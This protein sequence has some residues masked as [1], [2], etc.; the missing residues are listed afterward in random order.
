MWHVLEWIVERRAS[1]WRSNFMNWMKIRIPYPLGW[2]T[3][4][5]LL[6]LTTPYSTRQLQHLFSTVLL[7]LVL[8]CSSQCTLLLLYIYI[9]LY[10]YI[11]QRDW[12]NS[13]GMKFVRHTAQRHIMNIQLDA[14]MA[15][16]QSIIHFSSTIVRILRYINIY[17]YMYFSIYLRMCSLFCIIFF[18][19][20]QNIDLHFIYLFGNIYIVCVICI[21]NL[22]ESVNVWRLGSG[23]RCIF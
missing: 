9:Y 11:R 21:L 10:T 12:R 17:M 8:I 18:A 6:L 16:F 20:T 19:I 14:G 5:P 2:I 4:G 13:G 22:C 1:I 23:Y 7:M 15:A 3:C